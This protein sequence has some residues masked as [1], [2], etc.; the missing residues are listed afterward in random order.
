MVLLNIFE[1]SNLIPVRD[2]IYSFG[3]NEEE[4]VWLR[5]LTWLVIISLLAWLA[6]FFAKRI[7]LSVVRKYVQ[8]SEN[9]WDDVLMQRRLFSWFAHLAPALVIYLFTPVIFTDFP[10]VV[11]KMIK[12][13]TSIYMLI[14]L[15]IVVNS[16]LNGIKDIYETLEISK[17]RSITGYLQVIKILIFSLG[18][19][20]IIAIFIGKSP[21]YLFTGLGAIAAVLLL[22][23]KDTIL[24]FVASIQLSANNMVK[25][26]DWIS[27]PKHNA[28]GTIFE[29]TLNTVKVQNW[30]K[31][32]S[33]IPTY[34]LVS[35]SFSNWRGM[36]ESDGRRIKRSINIDMNSV[37]FCTDEML[38]RF[39]KIEL[40]TGYVRA[41]RVELDQAHSNEQDLFARTRKMTNLGTFRKYIENYLRV[42]P[43]INQEM[44]LMV[45]Q[46]Q[47]GE[48]GI[49]L[50]IYVFSSQKE[51][52]SY[53]KIQADIFDHLLA[54]VPEFGLRVYQAPTG[55]DFRMLKE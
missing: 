45:R 27:M 42:H 7:F 55:Y 43:A 48:T 51:W 33:T 14:I 40:L 8:R 5:M 47:P 12:T 25:P 32:I 4:T 3:F 35:E 34:A 37:I 39:E 2:W 13:G 9:K 49:P 30:D 10:E 52:T 11:A 18:I 41:K 46:L 28:D 24:G 29:I 16:F 6:D 1:G 50:E 15:L 38:N 23:F 17:N 22:V 31:T 53:E 44:T 20:W 54:F 19:I 36:E 21:F 26:G